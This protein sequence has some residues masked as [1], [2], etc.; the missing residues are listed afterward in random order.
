M[1]E[2]FKGGKEGRLI[3]FLNGIRVNKA[4]AQAYAKQNNTKLPSCL[5]KKGQ[6]VVGSETN[7]QKSRSRNTKSSTMIAKMP[8]KKQIGRAHV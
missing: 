3:Y 8:V 1:L 5:R 2:C 6:V 7:K 4:I